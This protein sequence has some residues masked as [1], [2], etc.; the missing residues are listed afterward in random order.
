ME[1]VSCTQ[2]R[3]LT[4]PILTITNSFAIKDKYCLGC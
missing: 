4:P 1:R 3:L 2:A